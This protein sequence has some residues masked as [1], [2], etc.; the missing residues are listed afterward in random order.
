ME[1]RPP[2]SGAAVNRSVA[3]EDPS[4]PAWQKYYADAS[5]RRRAMRKRYPNLL[6]RP[7]DIRRR[8][9]RLEVVFAACSVAFLGALTAIFHS[10]LSR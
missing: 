7:Q 2:A 10:L 1:V 9:R 8:K 6:Q 5:R 3:D 4:S